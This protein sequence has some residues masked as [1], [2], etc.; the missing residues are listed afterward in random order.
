MVTD[1][2]PYDN[3]MTKDNMM[4]FMEQHQEFNKNL[5]DR[6]DR[7]QKYLHKRLNKQDQGNLGSQNILSYCTKRKKNFF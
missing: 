5:S 1:N 2:E 3:S 6:L 7:Q 4:T